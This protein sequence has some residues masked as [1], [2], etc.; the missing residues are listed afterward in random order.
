MAYWCCCHCLGTHG[1]AHCKA[2][3]CL[4]SHKSQQG[5][6]ISCAL[7]LPHISYAATCL[8][9]PLIVAITTIR[10]SPCALGMLEFTIHVLSVHGSALARPCFTLHAT[11]VSHATSMLC[12]SLLS[13]MNCHHVWGG[14]VATTTPCH[15]QAPSWCSND[16][17]H[18]GGV[19]T[20][21][22]VRC[23]HVYTS[24]HV[25]EPTCGFNK[26][27][28]CA[29]SMFMASHHAPLVWPSSSHTFK[30]ISK[31]FGGDYKDVW[32]GIMIF[33]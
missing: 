26:A 20:P 24:L 5:T 12:L 13:H 22:L 3:P 23:G 21:C 11:R 31:V 7:L 19:A 33:Y 4:G 32:G 8:C 2:L 30:A 28:M 10:S 9:W 18:I 6:P 1:P 25:M 15:V 14:F 29:L 17:W 27:C 16:P